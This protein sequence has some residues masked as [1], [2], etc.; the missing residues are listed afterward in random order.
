VQS[1]YGWDWWSGFMYTIGYGYDGT[2]PYMYSDG[3]SMAC[4]LVAGV[5]GLIRSRA[6]HLDPAGV[7]QILLDTGQQ[8]TFDQPIGM[9]VDALAAMMALEA[10]SA[11]MP[12]APFQLAVQI[13]PNPFNPRTEIRLDLPRDGPVIVTL[14]DVRGRR[15]RTLIEGGIQRAGLLRLNWDG[16]D[17]TGRA[18]PSGLYVA[19]VKTGGKTAA[20]K[21]TLAR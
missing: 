1:N 9:K 17:D 6:A 4:P 12:P 8:L 18:L 2:N 16:C 3:T 11:P 21:M 13:T 10:S 15:V 14:H 7:R 20:T 5:C 19:R